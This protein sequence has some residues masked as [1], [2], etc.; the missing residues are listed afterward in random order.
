MIVFRYLN[1][2]YGLLALQQTKWK[3]GR[4]LELNDPLDCQPTLHRNGGADEVAIGDDPYFRELFDTVG[5]ICYSSKI[6]D[7]VIWSHY[8][9]CH[10]GIAFGFEYSQADGLFDVRYP[11]DDAR[12]RI[13][14][15]E[16]QRIK[17]DDTEVA[18]LQVICDGFTQKAKS[19]AYKCE[20]RQFLFLNGCEMIGPNYFRGMP[21]PHLRKIVLG[22][23]SRITESDIRRIKASWKTPYDVE[24]TRAQMDPRSYRLNA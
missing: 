10:R 15:D 23:K 22:V 24:I 9:D 13:D 7:P 2:Q 5:I 1:E 6:H 14:Y 11:D 4:L 21:L 3:I 12:A 19:W 8:A 18:L 16:L 20:Y 17:K